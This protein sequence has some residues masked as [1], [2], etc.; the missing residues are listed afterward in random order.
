MVAEY[1]GQLAEHFYYSLGLRQDNNDLFDDAA[2]YR[3]TGAYL[4]REA[5]T[6]LHA[7]L[8]SGVTNPGFFELYGF[9][10]GSFVGNPDTM[11]EFPPCPL[12]NKMF[13]NPWV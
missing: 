13:S 3:A 2:T 9:F 11:A 10:P 4:F 8:A 12:R 7:S 6:R 1:R 5:G